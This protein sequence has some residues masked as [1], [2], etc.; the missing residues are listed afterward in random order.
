MRTSVLAWLAAGNRWLAIRGSSSLCEAVASAK[1]VPARSPVR[2]RISAEWSFLCV[3][4]GQQLVSDSCFSPFR[5]HRIN[6][7]QT[8]PRTPQGSP[9][10]RSRRG[11][12]QGTGRPSGWRSRAA[13]RSPGTY[14]SAAVVRGTS[15]S[16]QLPRRH[17]H[18]RP[19]R[20]PVRQRKNA[21]ATARTGEGAELGC[22]PGRSDPLRGS[23]LPQ[24]R[25]QGSVSEFDPVGVA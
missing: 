23:V 12:R 21:S 17:Q 15:H 8:R 14:R 20:R 24:E 3:A 25:G 22:N 9:P 4:V 11:P 2:A 16:H 1:L 18:G 10:P 7:F 5:S 6:R 13:E 19:G